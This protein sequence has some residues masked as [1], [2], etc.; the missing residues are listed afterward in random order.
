MSPFV[1]LYGKE[2]RHWGIEANDTVGSP[3]PQLEAWLEERKLMQQLLQH[4]LHHATHQ[5]KN[6]AAKKRTPRS[7][8]PGDQVFVKLQPYVQSSVARRA[9][10]K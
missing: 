2:P 10:H 6:Q 1:D 5:M 8:A 3:L 4:N 9:N 7:F